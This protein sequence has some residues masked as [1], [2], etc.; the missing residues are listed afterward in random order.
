MIVAADD[1][2]LADHADRGGT[3][4]RACLRDG[5]GVLKL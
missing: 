5:F 2:L 4:G 3:L 1:G